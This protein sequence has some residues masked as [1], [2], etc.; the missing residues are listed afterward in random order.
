MAVRLRPKNAEESVADADYADCVE[1]QPEVF[2]H[3]FCLHKNSY[4]FCQNTSYSVQKLVH[5]QAFCS[6]N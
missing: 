1:L 3:S 4:F 2:S 6:S 5:Y